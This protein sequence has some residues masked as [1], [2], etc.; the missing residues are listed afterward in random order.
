M[1]LLFAYH[2]LLATERNRGSRLKV[3]AGE[4][5]RQV[6]L[7]ANAGLVEAALNNDGR[8]GSCTAIIRLTGAGR[9]FL[10]AFQGG[11][12]AG[13]IVRDGGPVTSG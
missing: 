4:P 9:Q 11:Q 1:N 13:L 8:A 7:M 5:D 12:V 10:R 2:L 3:A 6:R